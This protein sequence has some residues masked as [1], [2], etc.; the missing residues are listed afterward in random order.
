MSTTDPLTRKLG[1]FTRLSAADER[2]LGGL[3]REGVRGFGA[4][5]DI[6]REGE[7]P[8]GVKLVLSGWACR[9]KALED[10]RRQIVAFLVPGDLCDLNASIL[11]GMD[12]SVAALTP[13]SAADIP[14]ATIE[15]VMA[16]HPRVTQALLW[17]QLVTAAIQREWMLCL[18]RRTAFERVAHLL[19]EL[20]VRLRAVAL[21]VGDACE[22]PITQADLAEATGL[23]AVHVN[24]TLQELRGQG[25]IEL[26]GKQL[27]I[28]DLKA[29]Q[30]AAGF[31][32]DY[33]HL[34]REGRQHDANES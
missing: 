28:P 23:S 10:G 18:G 15:R 14:R 13:V 7:E 19:C 21:T 26:R 24:R 31:D 16:V 1:Q 8:R 29:V 20:F 12:H 22:L 27:V 6:I 25:L 30:D 11:R 33:L 4:R 5:E 34:D 17:E 9:Y 3:A 32:P 2:A